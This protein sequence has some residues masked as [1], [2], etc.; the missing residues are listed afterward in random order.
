M[1]FHSAFSEDLKLWVEGE[2]THD[3]GMARTGARRATTKLDTLRREVLKLASMEEDARRQVGEFAAQV[4]EASREWGVEGRPAILAQI[5]ADIGVGGAEQGDAWQQAEGAQDAAVPSMNELNVE[6]V[7]KILGLVVQQAEARVK[8]F[9]NLASLE[10]SSTAALVVRGTSLIPGGAAVG[11]DADLVRALAASSSEDSSSATGLDAGAPPPTG[12]V[13]PPREQ[14]PLAE[15]VPEDAEDSADGT[16][17]TLLKIVPNLEDLNKKR[18]PNELLSRPP[19]KY[20]HD[21][22]LLMSQTTGFPPG[23]SEVW[24][25]SREGKLDILETISSSITSTLGMESLDF[26][27]EH[28][29]KGKEV[30]K[31]LKL[32]QLLAIAAAWS[33]KRDD[34]GGQGASHANGVSKKEVTPASALPKALDAI[35]TVLQRA[36]DFVFGRRDGGD[37]Q[38]SPTREMESN[39]R[40]LQERIQEE[41]AIRAKLEAGEEELRRQVEES[42]AM[43]AERHAHLEEVKNAASNVCSRKHDLQRQL[44]ELR[45]GLMQRAEQCEGNPEVTRTKQELA[46]ISSKSGNS[47]VAKQELGTEVKKLQQRQVEAETTREKLEMEVR[48]MKLR[49]ASGVDGPTLHQHEDILLMQAEKQ[50]WEV[51]LQS[52]E[53]KM[54]SIADLNDL[55]IQRETQLMEDKKVVHSRHDDVALQL[56]VI[57]EER[58]GLRDGNEK[59]WHEKTRKEEE[60]QDTSNGYSHASDRLLEKEEEV[61]ELREQVEKFENLKEL[62]QENFEKA[63]HSPAQAAALPPIAPP[64]A[65]QNGK[66]APSPRRREDGDA[67][68]HYS[69]DSFEAA[70]ED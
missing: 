13:R 68:S 7:G 56:Q 22:A 3:N 28:V 47:T 57:V 33:L 5:K 60:L 43:L 14:R 64:A 44:E 70:D 19:P 30:P 46:E 1:L 34:G 27:P 4:V 31:T 41:L 63:R 66:A 11:P 32:L 42:R 59:L 9:G 24:P 35:A 50:K 58:D 2:E 29:L 39:C 62:L 45:A 67:S 15:W 55:E 36:T 26:D 54:R 16:E 65:A 40:I 53:E 49:F 18:S 12:G 37:G 23:L 17:A 21:V 20:V 10:I 52:L 38:S 25:D 69:N 48:R 6:D 8:E 61:F 51:N